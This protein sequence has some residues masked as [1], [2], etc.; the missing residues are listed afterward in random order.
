MMVWLGSPRLKNMLIKPA[1]DRLPYLFWLPCR[2][3]LGTVNRLWT[4]EEDLATSLGMT[5][6]CCS[7]HKCTLSYQVTGRKLNAGWGYRRMWYQCL[8]SNLLPTATRG[9]KYF[10]AFKTRG[11]EAGQLQITAWLELTWVCQEHPA[12]HRWPSLRPRWA[13]QILPRWKEP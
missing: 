13:S 11:S 2:A 5:K 3:S 9:I 1:Y 10:N 7:R 8:L 4:A 6:K 12:P